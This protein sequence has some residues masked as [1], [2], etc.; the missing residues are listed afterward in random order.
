MR[1]T[2]VT[3]NIQYG[4]EIETA[5]REIEQ[6]GV[7][8]GFDVLL[9]QE[10]DEAGTEAIAA[11]FDADYAF[12]SRH[13]HA[14]T[15]RDFGNA[16]VSRWPMFDRAQIDLPH[17]ARVRGHERHATYA[18][19]DI[20]GVSV[21]CFS[22]HTEVPLLPLAKRREQ[23]AHLATN[24]RDG[25]GE[26]VLLG[27]DFN[28]MT[29]RGLKA[30]DTALDDS[31]LDRVSSDIG[32]TFRRGAVTMR[33]DHVFAAGFRTVDVGSTPTAAS[34]H[35]PLWVELAPTDAT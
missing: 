25:A 11:A 30:L 16:V 26:R 4:I 33:L 1:I 27:G 19:T 29:T 13:A 7:L 34:D 22:V 14:N 23:F 12:A 20:D 31:G 28:T 35:P 2:V 17:A 6:S 10:M 5:I 18:R 8:S 3:W 32:P 9:L 15:G 21:G 24:I